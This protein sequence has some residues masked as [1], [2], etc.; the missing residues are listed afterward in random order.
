VRRLPLTRFR[1]KF[2]ERVELYYTPFVGLYRLLNVESYLYFYPQF[3]EASVRKCLEHTTMINFRYFLIIRL[4]ITLHNS[5][6]SAVTLWSQR[7]TKRRKINKNN[8]VCKI[9]LAD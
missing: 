1:E 5:T 2:K 7:N 4:L 9:F 3:L 8:I 6:L